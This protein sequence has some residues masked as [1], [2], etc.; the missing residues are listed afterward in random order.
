MDQE[1]IE[2][3]FVNFIVPKFH[4]FYGFPIKQFD[5]VIFW[6]AKIDLINKLKMEKP[7]LAHAPG[8]AF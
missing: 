7:K 2:I 6:Q 1:I 5:Q 3:E 4:H 8:R